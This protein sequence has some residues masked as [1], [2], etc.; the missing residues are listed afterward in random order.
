PPATRLPG[1][2]NAVSRLEAKLGDLAGAPVE[3][4]RPSNPEHGDYASNVALQ[5]APTRKR[6]PRELAEE[7]ARA[8]EGLDEVERA[9]V[10]GPGFVN[11]WI[12]PAWYGEALAEIVE[13]GGG[14]GGG[15]LESKQRVQVECVS[16]N[17][18]GP[19]TVAAARNGVIGDCVARM[20][21]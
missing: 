3:L 6:S 1:S 19:I 13:A 4:E 11:L 9:E 21:E 7:I 18:T 15:F 8:A 12:A 5:L 2:P 14:Y 17:P 10:A 16:A 20:L